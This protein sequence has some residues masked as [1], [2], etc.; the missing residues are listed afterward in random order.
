MSQRDAKG[1]FSKGAA[2][3]FKVGDR[4]IRKKSSAYAS[5][6]DNT[7]PIGTAGTI[8]GS[9]GG[10]WWLVEWDGHPYTKS[11]IT[12]RPQEIYLPK[13]LAFLEPAP[14][15][16]AED[17]KRDLRRSILCKIPAGEL[18][19]L[20]AA[21]AAKDAES[22]RR[23]AGLERVE[24]FF[25]EFGVKDL[26]E[27]YRNMA[28]VDGWARGFGKECREAAEGT[29]HELATLKA[30]VERLEASR[31]K[32]E[33]AGLAE[34]HRAEARAEAAEAKLAD[35]RAFFR[36]HKLLGGKPVSSVDDAVLMILD[37]TA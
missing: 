26:T 27:A 19:D 37:G 30:E 9:H 17:P 4:V 14:Q 13:E 28:Q 35:I 8:T 25:E 32:W 12:G 21:L 31:K 7:V 36:V 10:G 16:K 2:R 20:K 24:D 34:Q 5:N 22:E 33:E 23:R 3:Q 15:P 1:R 6:F 11:E 29:R 18:E